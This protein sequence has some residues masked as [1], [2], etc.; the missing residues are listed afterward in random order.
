MQ[1]GGSADS[2][3]S[4]LSITYGVSTLSEIIGY[5]LFCRGAMQVLLHVNNT[6]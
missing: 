4:A 6:G 3:D 2:A 1:G 5:Q